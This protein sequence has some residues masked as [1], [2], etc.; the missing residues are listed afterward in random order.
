MK[1]LIQKLLLK[2]IKDSFVYK[3][4]ETNLIF[5]LIELH[6]SSLYFLLFI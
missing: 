1:N 4:N 3:K 5:N 2:I 6:L